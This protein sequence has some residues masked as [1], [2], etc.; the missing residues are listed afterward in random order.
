MKEP[1]HYEI[2]K[3]LLKNSLIGLEIVYK[4]TGV[5]TAVTYW[6]IKSHSGEIKEFN[7][8][9]VSSYVTI[10]PDWSTLLTLKN[11]VEK[12]IVDWDSFVRNN[13]L[14]YQQYL[15]LKEKFES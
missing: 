3:W 2:K 10:S 11:D 13:K 9:S 5:D 15:K 7:S 4:Q 14:E 6:R 1:K 8:S 12:E